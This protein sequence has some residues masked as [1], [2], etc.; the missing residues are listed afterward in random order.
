NWIPADYHQGVGNNDEYTADLGLLLDTEGTYYYATRYQYLEQDYVYGGYSLSQ[1]GFWDGI[2]NISGILLVSTEVVEDSINWA[3]LQWPGEG[4]IIPNQEFMVYGQVYIED[5]TS[6]EE[7]LEGLQ[8][9]IG[10]SLTDSE[11][12]SWTNWIPADYH[13]GVGNNDEYTAD[14]GLLLDTEGTYYYATRYQYLEQD[15]VYG[16]YSISGGGFWN[17]D[18]NVSGVLTVIPEVIDSIGWANLQWPANGV[19]EPN[20]NYEVFGRV[21]IENITNQ[22]DSIEELQVWVGYHSENT[23]PNTW[24]DWVPAYYNLGIGAN[25]EYKANLGVA[26]S[27][28]GLYYYATRY[29][30]Q[31]QDFVYGGY[32]TSDGGFWDG[33]NNVSGE[34]TV[35][36]N[37]IDTIAWANLQWPLSGDIEP[38]Q[39]FNVYGRVWIDDI[40]S[41]EDSLQ[42]LQAWVGYSLDDTDPSTWT[43]WIPA[44]YHSAIGENDQYVS[45][46]GAMISEEGVYYYA[47]RFQYQDQ[48]YVYGGHS[49]SGGD[50]WDGI[51]YL[52]GVLTVTA[53]P[54]TDISWANLQWPGSGEIEQGDGFV[55]YGQAY[56]EDMTSQEDS[57]QELQAWVGYSTEN[58]DPSTWT[59]WLPAYYNQGVGNNDEYAMDLGINIPAEGVYYYA[60]RFQFEDQDLVYGG[61]SGTNG[62]FWDGVNNTSGMLTVLPNLN[63]DSIGWAN[64]QWPGAGNIEPLEE[65][66]VYGQVWMEDLSIQ[67]DSIENLQAWVGYS[68]EDTDPSTWTEWIPAY[69][70]DGIDENDE[71]L[72][73]LG[74]LM[75]D[76]GTYYYATRF[77]YE[78]QE[79]VYGGFS[80]GGGGFWDGSINASGILNVTSLPVTDILWANLQWPGSGEIGLEEEFMVYGQA[81]I[82]ELTGGAD[83]L[84]DLQAWVG[85]NMENTNPNT[86]TTWV[87]AYYLGASENNDEYSM[88]LGALMDTEGVFYYATRFQYQDQDM[89]YGGFSEAN[90]G[91]WDGINNLNGVLTVSDNPITDSI[92][93]ANLQW[94]G[95]G[96]IEVEE[97][98]MVYGQVWI[99]GI[100]SQEDSISELQAW[101]GYSLENTDPSTWTDW[102]P[103]YYQIG[104]G[105]ND[106]YAADLGAF[107]TSE[108]TY[109][110]ST[111][112]QYEN[113]DYA[114][115]GF[116]MD[117][118]GFWNGTDYINGVL[119]VTGSG[120]SSSIDWANLQ[121]PGSAEIAPLDE[122]LVYGQVWMDG[123]TIQE[124][125]LSELKAWVG[126]HTE[127]TDPSTWDNW[128]LADYYLGV[129]ENDEYIFDLGAEMS[130]E[131]IYYYAFK[132]QYEDEDFVYGGYSAD[133]GG[134]WNGTGNVNGVLTVSDQ[135]SQAIEWANLQWPAQG[136]I[137]LGEDFEIFGQVWIDGLTI[138]EGELE[139]LQAW[140]GYSLVNTDP[141]TWQTWVPASYHS[142]IGAN[143]E[144]FANI[145]PDI[146]NAAIYYYATRYQYQEQDFVY[147]G[148]S[149]NGGGFWDGSEYQSGIL[150]VKSLTPTYRVNFIA[151][152][153]TQLY[154][155]IKFKGEMTNWNKVDM[156]QTGDDW[157]LSLELEPGTYEWG[158]MEDDGTQDGIWLVIGEQLFVTVHDQGVVS[159][160]IFY[161]IN[162]TAIEEFTSGMQIY[163]N[164]VHNQ[165]NI[166]RA[167]DAENLNYIILDATGNRVE[168]GVLTSSEK[169][170]DLSEL[171]RGVYILQISDDMNQASIKIIKQ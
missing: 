52:S 32:S 142:N 169:S 98:F 94:P 71:Y 140:V 57:L 112:F 80:E 58:T 91:F 67:E 115:G 17:A 145:G 83:S 156:I 164:P 153:A 49:V 134:F 63:T 167:N 7:A 127:N 33:V 155:N 106:E 161:E 101:V 44:Y 14:L 59:E 166:D 37:P 151:T 126:Y 168:Q 41:Q 136:E 51:D 9:W 158:V 122:L 124:D 97:S 131:G 104:M 26:L 40:T 19:I 47:T 120:S 61:F 81:Y 53:P 92:G 66:N 93:W 64:L 99:D 146:D 105:D 130:E 84:I 109:Y 133:G 43:N 85:F 114:Y 116:S 18:E 121:W 160:D 2:D 132:Y 100:T 111:R 89:V 102:I 152:D 82:E 123:L 141:S 30:Y 95:N 65:F 74:A 62:G 20:E 73:N 42:E 135:A 23:D 165:L 90:G 117:G 75:S 45:N 27:D 144:Y 72:A 70:H 147:G 46:I 34:L 55:I 12:S 3:N 128:I 35:T 6:Q 13:Q 29:Q 31:D 16:G 56:I 11:P 21:W 1:G 170:I 157:S 38:T 76:E 77:Q 96:E 54:M 88:D 50:F 10:Y 103:A 118:G 78:E 60:T 154:S 162:F 5:L 113:Q 28:E 159:G 163:P 25:D 148:Y 15:Y 79:F 119:T 48:D 86:W 4:E 149:T 143:D 129:D 24:T 107:M 171:A 108:G 125:S 138:E 39:E 8:A 68:L 150:T 110:Y 87:P 36:N 69:Y 137:F 139:G 22:A